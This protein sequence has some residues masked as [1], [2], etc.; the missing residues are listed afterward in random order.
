MER[1]SHCLQT[2]AE[3]PGMKW[4]LP[5]IRDVMFHALPSCHRMGVQPASLFLNILKDSGKVGEH[6][7]SKRSELVDCIQ[8][9]E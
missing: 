9:P 4:R 2:P 5:G 6:N 3:S 1:N 7:G 8:K